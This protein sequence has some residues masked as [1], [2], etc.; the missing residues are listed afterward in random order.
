MAAQ[1]VNI[2]DFEFINMT[3]LYNV[4]LCVEDP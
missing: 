3:Y 1:D 4:R 2:F